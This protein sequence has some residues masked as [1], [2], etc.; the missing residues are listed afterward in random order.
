MSFYKITFDKALKRQVDRLPGKLRQ[1]ASQ[2]LASLARNPRPPGA[3]ELK[4]HPG[5]Y[6][7]WL[8]DGRYRAVW[9][10]IESEKRVEI[11]YVGPKP[12]YDE[13]LID[14]IE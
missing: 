1:E 7:K 4:G 12:D 3:I 2:L 13:L 10:I 9:E 6:R 5:I 8:T 14:E 11:F